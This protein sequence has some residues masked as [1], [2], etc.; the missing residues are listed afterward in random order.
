[1]SKE[2]VLVIKGNRSGYAI[3]YVAGYSLT[4]RELIEKLQYIDPETKIVI[5]NDKTSYGF[6]TYGE[7]DTIYSVDVD[8]EGDI[9]SM[10]KLY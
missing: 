2:K 6:Y 4:V 9:E 1:M 8:A 10:N 5:G 7:L 3:D